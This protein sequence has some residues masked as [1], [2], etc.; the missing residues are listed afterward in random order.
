ML[1]FIALRKYHYL[2][3][4]KIKKDTVVVGDPGIGLREISFSEFYDGFDHVGMFL[5]PN[6]EFLK[7]PESTAPWK[8]YLQL[9]K[10]LEND[11]YLAFICGL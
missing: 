6:T 5:K 10:G 1:P 11:M 7:Q 2:V 9:F 4:Y 3:V 8:H